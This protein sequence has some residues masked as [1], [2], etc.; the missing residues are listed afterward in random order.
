MAIDP[1]DKELSRQLQKDA[2][3]DALQ[4]D[5]FRSIEDWRK[6]YLPNGIPE[7]PEIPQLN[8]SSGQAVCQVSA[9]GSRRIVTLAQ[10]EELQRR[11]AA[12]LTDAQI[13]AIAKKEIPAWA[14][15]TNSTRA[16]ARAIERSVVDAT[17]ERC[18]HVCDAKAADYEID[19]EPGRSRAA[20][21][22]A[23]AIRALKQ[24]EGS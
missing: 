11:E 8:A 16:F 3:A 18:A 19:F 24:R 7:Q 9:G 20:E 12:M 21:H 4:A 14:E 17:I 22:C 5:E 1:R 10:Y 2:M 23:D 15:W 13:D 6:H